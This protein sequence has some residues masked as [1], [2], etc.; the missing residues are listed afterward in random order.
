MGK[1]QK[2]RC[3]LAITP[4]EEVSGDIVKCEQIYSVGNSLPINIQ[5]V[6]CV[7][8][9][10]LGK[11]TGESVGFKNGRHERGALIKME[12]NQLRGTYEWKSLTY[13]S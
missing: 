10:L 5:E 9:Q 3:V 4:K 2:D 12:A 1:L 11:V 6:E 7:T 13:S 8:F